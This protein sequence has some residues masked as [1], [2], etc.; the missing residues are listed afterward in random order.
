[1][2]LQGPLDE[3]TLKALR[4]MAQD[5]NVVVWSETGLD[6]LPTS[7]AQEVQQ[8]AF[9]DQIFEPFVTTKD[10]GT[11]LG[12]P[13]ALRMI[14]AQGGVLR[15]VSAEPDREHGAHFRIEFQTAGEDAP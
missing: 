2:D 6:Y 13:M 10:T 9:R 7:P 4:M 15:L 5:P 8:Q 12:L 1:M 14:E 11:G 3:D